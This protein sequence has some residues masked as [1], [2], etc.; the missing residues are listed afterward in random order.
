MRS[1]DLGDRFDPLPWATTYTENAWA[2][3]GSNCFSFVQGLAIVSELR[4]LSAFYVY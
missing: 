4:Y 1:K 3:A 2:T